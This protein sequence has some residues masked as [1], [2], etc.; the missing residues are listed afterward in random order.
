LRRACIVVPASNWSGS[1]Y[2]GEF[3]N[4][5]TTMARDDAGGSSRYAALTMRLCRK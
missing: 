4:R 3:K 2:T 5:F 1:F